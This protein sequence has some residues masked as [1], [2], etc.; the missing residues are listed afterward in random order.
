V[1]LGLVGALVVYR[2]PV[3]AATAAVLGYRAIALVVPAIMG[4][5]ALALLRRT[6]AREALDV[7]NCGPGG[8]VE[9]IGRGSIQLV[10]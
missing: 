5:V 8:S 2:V 1:D 10:P 7:A 3:G 4:G 6:L 9:V